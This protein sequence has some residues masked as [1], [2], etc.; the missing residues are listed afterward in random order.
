LEPVA[1]A[2]GVA[3]GVLVAFVGAS[4]CDEMDSRWKMEDGRWKIGY[5]IVD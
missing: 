2:A 4:H 5:S 3:I 1:L